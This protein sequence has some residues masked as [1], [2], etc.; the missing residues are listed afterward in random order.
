MKNEIKLSKFRRILKIGLFVSILVAVVLLVSIRL[1]LGGGEYYEDIS[2]APLF[3]EDKL[4]IVA[5]LEMPPGNL[6]VSKE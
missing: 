3:G 5:T 4:E 2:T 1:F 6:A